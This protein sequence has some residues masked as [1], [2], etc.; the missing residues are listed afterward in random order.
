MADKYFTYAA[1]AS[2]IFNQQTKRL[3]VSVTAVRKYVNRGDLGTK[4]AEG[5]YTI[6]LQDIEEFNAIKR[7]S[8]RP[9]LAGPEKG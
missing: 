6:T 4:H 7:T 9:S 1:A 3:G 2:L 8:G 5:R